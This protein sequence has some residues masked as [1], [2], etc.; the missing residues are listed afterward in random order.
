MIITAQE[1]HDYQHHPHHLKSPF[2]NVFSQNFVRKLLG[3]FTSLLIADCIASH[4]SG[5]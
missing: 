1:S 5:W 3:A 2:F 4:F